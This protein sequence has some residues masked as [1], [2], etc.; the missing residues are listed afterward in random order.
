MFVNGTWPNEFSIAVPS[1]RLIRDT[2]SPVAPWSIIWLATCLKMKK[3]EKRRVK[4]LEPPIFGAG[5]YVART[6]GG[7]HG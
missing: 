5:N 7:G 2:A 4:L 3:V 1:M 6:R